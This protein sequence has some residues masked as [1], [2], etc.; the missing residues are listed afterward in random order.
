MIACLS[1][2]IFLNTSKIIKKNNASHH[3]IDFFLDYNN[4]NSIQ[5]LKIHIFQLIINYLIW[6]LLWLADVQLHSYFEFVHIA[7][8]CFSQD[9]SRENSI[10]SSLFFFSNIKEGNYIYELVCALKPKVK[11]IGFNKK[12]L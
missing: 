4:N 12:D 2:S 11:C 1:L 10:Q 8:C 3:H 6:L 9:S 5:I 7:I